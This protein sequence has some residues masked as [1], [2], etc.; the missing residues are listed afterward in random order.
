MLTADSVRRGQGLSLEP[1]H[2]SSLLV[3]FLSHILGHTSGIQNRIPAGFPS[4]RSSSLR[5]LRISHY[6]CHVF[7]LP[8]FV[9]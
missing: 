6:G 5:E 4:F 7:V 9:F 3:W 1:T 8:L 2:Y